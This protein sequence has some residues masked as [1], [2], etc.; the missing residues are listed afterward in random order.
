MKWK[1]IVIQLYE[2]DQA[3]FFLPWC[4]GVMEKQILGEEQNAAARSFPPEI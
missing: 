1:I 3:A 4:D 2:P